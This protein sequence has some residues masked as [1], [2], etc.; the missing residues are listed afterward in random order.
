M[1]RGDVSADDTR[2][3]LL[4]AGGELFAEAGFEAVTVREICRRANANVAAINYHFGDK[5]GLY[6]E[7]ILSRARFAEN[8]ARQDVHGPPEEQLRFFV[9][10]YVTGLLD[11][12]S[13]AW[14]T[15]LVAAE[16][17]RPSPVLKRVVKEIIRP[18]EARLRCIIAAITGLP[19]QDD[20]VR[21]CAHSIIG[22]CLHYKHAEHVLSF[23]WPDLWSTPGR[24]EKVAE[25]IVQFSLSALHDIRRTNSTKPAKGRQHGGSS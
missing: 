13:P 10:R 2:A 20:E 4:Q 7:I 5:L 23:L 11:A 6:T 15:K 3:K 18:T 24:L 9:H 25:H 21:M 12:G 8:A 14:L 19:E 22:Q 1:Q 17:S 16:T